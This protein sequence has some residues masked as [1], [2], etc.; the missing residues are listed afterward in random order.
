[1]IFF[2]FANFLSFQGT[3]DF[4]ESELWR[5]GHP[6]PSLKVKSLH[7]LSAWIRLLHVS[8]PPVALLRYHLIMAKVIVDHF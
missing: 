4:L 6:N 3:V 1:M 2:I 5:F 8:H 7:G